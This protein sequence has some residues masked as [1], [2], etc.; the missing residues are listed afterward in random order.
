[1]L[2]LQRVKRQNGSGVLDGYLDDP[3]GCTFSANNN[4]CGVAARRCHPTA[5][6]PTRR[7]PST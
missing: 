7:R 2:Q 6:P 1:M 5:S 3:R 4:I